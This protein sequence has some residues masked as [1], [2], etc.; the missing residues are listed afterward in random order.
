MQEKI[1][2]LTQMLQDLGCTVTPQICG[3]DWQD[4]PER[5]D[6]LIIFDILD[7]TDPAPLALMGDLGI[8]HVPCNGPTQTVKLCEVTLDNFEATANKLWRI[9]KAAKDQ[10]L[11]YR[12]GGAN[13][14]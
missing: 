9:A 7:E 3:V 14:I 5:D 11:E 10:M 2:K 1:E 6:Y 4:P 13:D 12:Y 8:T